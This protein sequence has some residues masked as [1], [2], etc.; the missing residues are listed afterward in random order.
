MW[1]YTIH[2][3]P[4]LRA[5]AHASGH[6]GSTA[7]VLQVDVVIQILVSGNG[8]EWGLNGA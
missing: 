5:R 2:I 4:H 3:Q 6:D 1:G 7:A 8:P